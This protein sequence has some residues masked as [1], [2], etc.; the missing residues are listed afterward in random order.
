M[1]KA[2]PKEAPSQPVA[3]VEADVFDRMNETNDVIEQRAYEL[4]QERGGQ[5]GADQDDWFAAETEILRS[6]HVTRSISSNQVSLA[7]QVP[8]FTADD[9]EVSLGHR[10]AV[11][12]GIHRSKGSSP[13][14][15]PYRR[16]RVMQIIELP[17]DVD[18]KRTVA[19]FRDGVLNVVL[20]RSI[21]IE[22][23]PQAV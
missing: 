21:A 14:G 17:Y 16:T 20:P 13:D 15:M 3:V 4:Y 10:R 7:V 1:A 19:N 8:N 12:C 2:M 6:P 9:L 5:H 22:D 23:R 11:I 18:P